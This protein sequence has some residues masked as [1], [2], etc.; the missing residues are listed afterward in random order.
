MSPE[1]ISPPDEKSISIEQCILKA[2]KYIDEQGVCLFLY[3]V[4]GSKK[5]SP[6]DRQ[7]LQKNLIKIKNELNI[8]FSEYFPTNTLRCLVEEDTGATIMGGD[9]CLIGINN[10]EVIPKIVDYLKENCPEASFHYN[11][12]K[13][14]WDDAIKTVK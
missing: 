4:K 6:I 5:Y 14:G 10:A 7:S 2:Q 13:D 1:R 8:K 3:D 12:A 9:G 11:V